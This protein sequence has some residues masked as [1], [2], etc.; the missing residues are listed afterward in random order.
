MPASSNE[1][2]DDLGGLS[3]MESL[4]LIFINL[5]SVGIDK[6]QWKKKEKAKEVKKF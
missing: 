5:E 4:V 6:N 1:G 2:G 3:Q